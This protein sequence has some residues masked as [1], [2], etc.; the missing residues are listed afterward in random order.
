MSFP[1]MDIGYQIRKERLR[2]E[3]VELTHGLKFVSGVRYNALTDRLVEAGRLGRKTGTVY[4]VS[5]L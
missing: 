4:R 3:G 2:E 1:G 5:C